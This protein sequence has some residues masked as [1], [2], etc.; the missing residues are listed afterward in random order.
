MQ[1]KNSNKSPV[2]TEKYTIDK[3]S[4]KLVSTS[5]KN[6][7]KGFSKTAIISIKFSENIKTSTKWSDIYIKNLNTGNK[8]GINKAI[9][10][11]TLYIKM[12]KKR[13]GYNTYQV[14][15]PAGTVKD[16]AGNNI[17]KTASF[18]FKTGK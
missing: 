17:V 6:G 3:I 10:N 1:L 13:Y 8:V 7:A 14:Y 9:K 15:I 18:K 16:N 4:P 2:Y 12:T 11:N 5:P